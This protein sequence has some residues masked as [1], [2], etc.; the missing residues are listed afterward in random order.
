V[1]LSQVRETETWLPSEAQQDNDLVSSGDTSDLGFD[2]GDENYD[3]EDDDDYYDSEL[4]GSG[5]DG[6]VLIDNRIPE[7]RLIP[8]DPK[9]TIN[10]MD[11]IEQNEVAP[12]HLHVEMS[13]AT[14]EGFF[15]QTEV[16]IALIAGG[17]VGLLFAVLLILLLIY[18]MKKKDE[19]SYDLGKKPIYKKAPTAEIYA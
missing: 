18:R 4:S 10:D 7:G 11:L 1:L 9:P 8:K 14:D 12:K 6:P 13:H 17:V 19:G 2:D 5:D 15:K 16:V 3:D